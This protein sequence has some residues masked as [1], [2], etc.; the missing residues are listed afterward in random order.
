MQLKNMK[1]FSN[2]YTPT[3]QQKPADPSTVMT[4]EG[5]YQKILLSFGVLLLGGIVGWFIP[6]LMLPGLIG[7]IVLVILI[8]VKQSKSPGLILSYTALQGLV[9]GGL[10]SMLERMYTGITPQI[11]IATL[12]VTAVIFFGQRKGFLKTTPRL[13]KIFLYSLIGLIGFGIINLILTFTGVFTAPF[14]FY[15]QSGWIG[16]A[17]S[18]F[19]IIVASYSFVMDFEYIENGVTNQLEKNWEWYATFSFMVTFVWMYTE[20]ARLFGIARS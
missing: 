17:L 5:T 2:S 4:Y 13:T 14:G 20:I 10:S 8:S 19:S 15:G 1:E 3:L 7:G 9:L 18:V 16:I 11:I 12:T 6:A